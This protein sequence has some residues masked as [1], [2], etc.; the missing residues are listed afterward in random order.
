MAKDG[1]PHMDSGP[2][3][4]INAYHLL[5]DGQ[6]R[7]WQRWYMTYF[8]QVRY[9]VFHNTTGFIHQWL[10]QHRTHHYGMQE[11][12]PNSKN[13]WG[14]RERTT[15]HVHPLRPTVAST[16]TSGVLFGGATDGG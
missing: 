5:S 10:E 3:V 1:A 9:T 16:T 8:L 4:D 6:Q 2:F 15:R 11:V 7:L 13:H 12:R 14:G